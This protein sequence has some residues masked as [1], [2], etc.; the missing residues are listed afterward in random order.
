LISDSFFLLN[1]NLNLNLIKM[2]KKKIFPH[3]LLNFF[4]AC[5]TINS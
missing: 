1:L 2:S 5:G 4:S 3:F